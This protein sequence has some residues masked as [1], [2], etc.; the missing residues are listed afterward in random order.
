MM[1]IMGSASFYGEMI[2]ILFFFWLADRCP[3]AEGLRSMGV[4]DDAPTNQGSNCHYVL[5]KLDGEVAEH[6]S[7]CSSISRGPYHHQPF[8]SFKKAHNDACVHT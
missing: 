4:R 6:F 3:R 2:S 7:P 5:P 8:I 1:S